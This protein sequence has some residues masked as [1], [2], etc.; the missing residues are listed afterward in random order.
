MFDNLVRSFA[1]PACLCFGFLGAVSALAAE[2]S[3]EP[4]SKASY[5]VKPGDT[6]DKVVRTAFPNSPLRPDLLRDEITRLNPAA[7]TK[8]SP[9]VLMAGANLQ[10]PEHDA[11]LSK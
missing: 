2:P 10:L 3:A 1:V 4:A 9:K 5:L 7:F 6:L 11:L 8:G